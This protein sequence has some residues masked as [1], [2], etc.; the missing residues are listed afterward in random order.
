MT[1]LLSARQ[2]KAARALLKW[3]R[4]DL[5]KES[6][7]SAETVKNIEHSIY[8]PR[9]ETLTTLVDTFARH[10]V[11]FVYYETLIGGSTESNHNGLLQTLSY[12]GAVHVTAS[13]PEIEEDV[14]VSEIE[15]AQ[16]TKGGK[17]DK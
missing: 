10:G 15:G 8:I 6:G 13:T 17:P 7:M 1:R 11:Q 4:K 3:T 5:A 2:I 16:K 9:K 12:A 14:K